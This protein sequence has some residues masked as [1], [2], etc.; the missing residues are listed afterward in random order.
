MRRPRPTE[1]VSFVGTSLTPDFWRLFA[2]LLVIFTAI[3]FVVS[4]ALDVLVLRTQQR[5][6]ST[7]SRTAPA[8]QPRRALARR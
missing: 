1:E 7:E 3:T 8:E 2:V 5:R 6:R 4:A